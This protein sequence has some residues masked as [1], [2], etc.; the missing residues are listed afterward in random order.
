MLS[1]GIAGAII[2]RLSVILLGTATLQ[3]TLNMT[4]I[5]MKHIETFI[6]MKRKYAYLISS[7]DIAYFSL[8]FYLF[9]FI[10]YLSDNFFIL[11]F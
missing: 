5:Y 1:Y 3:V 2:F 6:I 9:P 10:Y 8:C 4:Y 11:L 7:F